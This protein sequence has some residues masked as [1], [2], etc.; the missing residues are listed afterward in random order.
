MRMKV[1]E[2][3]MVGRGRGVFVL[4]RGCCFGCYIS[5]GLEFWMEWSD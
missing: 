5:M 3:V 4:E 1:V 2:T